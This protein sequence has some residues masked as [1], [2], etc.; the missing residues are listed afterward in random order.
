MLEQ[1]TW[2]I[3][4]FLPKNL[5]VSDRVFQ[6]QVLLTTFMVC[7]TPKVGAIV[8]SPHVLVVSGGVNLRV[9]PGT[10]ISPSILPNRAKIDPKLIWT[11]R[12]LCDCK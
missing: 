5:A 11:L 2:M 10:D 7:Q 3:H 1:F 12:R 6:A 9:A 8:V 4:Y